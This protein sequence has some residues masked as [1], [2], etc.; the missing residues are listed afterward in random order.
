MAHV[1]VGTDHGEWGGALFGLDLASGKWVVSVDSFHHVTGIAEDGQGKLWAGWS[2]LEP[3]TL[4]RVHRPDATVEQDN[5]RLESKYIQAVA[6]DDARKVLYGVERQSLVRF[7]DFTP[8]EFASLGKLPYSDRYD[9]G[10]GPGITGMMV[11]G[12]QRF[13]VVHASEAP[14]VYADGEVVA[15][16]ME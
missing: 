2:G 5:L 13:L 15:L 12:P 8:V 7:E 11:L 6:W 1:W 3:N 10:M 14:R 9:V 16:P 4:L